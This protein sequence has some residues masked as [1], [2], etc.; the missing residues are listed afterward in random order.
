MSL[1][2]FKKSNLIRYKPI[3]TGVKIKKLNNV[4]MFFS[5]RFFIH[6]EKNIKGLSFS[7]FQFSELIFDEMVQPHISSKICNKCDTYTC[8]SCS[9]KLRTIIDNY[10]EGKGQAYINNI[11]LNIFKNLS[12]K[13]N[14][15]IK[16]QGIDLNNNNFLYVIS[17]GKIINSNCFYELIWN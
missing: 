16:I 1:I 3:D 4:T 5:P 11:F 14:L 10:L 15:K 12:L 8:I 13:F 9:I 2:I 6:Q 7:D 17:N